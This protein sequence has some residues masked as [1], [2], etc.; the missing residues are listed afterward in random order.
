MSFLFRFLFVQH[1]LWWSCDCDSFS[2]FT[3]KKKI[4]LY[5]EKAATTVREDRR[6]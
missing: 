5:L 4:I 2:I 3:K 1:R 6:S